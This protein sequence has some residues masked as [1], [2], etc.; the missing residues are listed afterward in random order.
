MA[1]PQALAALATRYWDEHLQA[2]PLLATEIG[3]RRFDDRLPDPTPAARIGESG[4]PARAARARGVAAGRGAVRRRSRDA[5]RCCW[6]RLTPGS[7]SELRAR[8]LGGRRARRHAGGV[9]APARAAAGAHRRGGL[10]AGGAHGEDGRASSTRRPP[11]CGAAWRQGR[12]PP[13]RRLR[14]VL[15]QL[16]DLLAKP[17]DKWPLRA[18]AAAPHADWPAPERLA[19]QRA[20]DAAI[21]AA[22]RPAF[23]R[24]RALL[25]A[26]ILPRARDEAHAGILQ[27]PG[28]RGLLREA[29]Q[30][31]HLAGAAGGGDP[32]HRARGA[33][34]HPRRDGAHRQAAFGTGALPEL[35]RSCAAIRRRSSARA[36]RSRRRRAR[37]S[38]ARR[39]R[40]R[41]FSAG[42]RARPAWS[43][44]ST[45]SRRRTRRSPT[46]AQ[47]AIDGSRPAA[48]YV[49]TYKPETRARYEVE[50][51]AFHESVP[52]P[53]HPD[54]DRAGAD[55][56]ARVPQAPRASPPSSKDGA[57]TRRGWPTSWACTRA[58]A[59]GWAG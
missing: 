57:C 22:I 47:P 9:H 28:R 25:R 10:E 53:P 2:H 29:D 12:S 46:T 58:R 40:S 14:R 21:A 49:N 23:E 13:P 43:S 19:F 42:C 4:R 44:A 26:E 11:T 24:Q 35:Q 32:P 5:S 55:R 15:G 39:R 33:G 41:G 59:T 6:A 51:L 27:R 16:D 48:Y 1:P 18:P 37:R 8:R 45:P 36:A 3:D 56:P 7:R 54:R 34:A 30:G 17:D 38:R 31:S 50:A 52:G 20:V